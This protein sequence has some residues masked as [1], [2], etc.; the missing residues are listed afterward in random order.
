MKI[1]KLIKSKIKKNLT[2]ISPTLE[3]K[4][5]YRFSFGKKLDLNN[6]KTF[7]EKILWFKLNTYNNNELITNYK[8]R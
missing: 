5:S 3:T 7:N 4:I 8:M 2:L 1:T 6:P